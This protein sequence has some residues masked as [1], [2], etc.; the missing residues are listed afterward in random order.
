LNL[1][2]RAAPTLLTIPL[3]PRTQTR[4]CCAVEHSGWSHKRERQECQSA[5]VYPVPMGYR[6]NNVLQ[7]HESIVVNALCDRSQSSTPRTC[8]LRPNL[9]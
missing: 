1:L 4:V 6:A 9:L 8:G 2:L 7:R 5:L 3:S